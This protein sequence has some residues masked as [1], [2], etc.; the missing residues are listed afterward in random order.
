LA[1]DILKVT[2]LPFGGE[3][4][5]EEEAPAKKAKAKKKVQVEYP[6]VGVLFSSF[7]VQ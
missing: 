3:E 4:E 6:V 7:I 5:D 1:L 2:T